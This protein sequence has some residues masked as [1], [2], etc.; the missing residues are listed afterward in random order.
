MPGVFDRLAG[1][2]DVVAELTAAASAARARV[3][4]QGWDESDARMVH[5]WLFTG[6]PG[7]GRSVAATCFAAA[8][9][10]EHPE[11][12]GCGECRSCHTVLA[13]THADVHLLA[14]QGVNILL[15]DVKETIHRAASRPSTGRWQIVVVEEADRLTEQSGNALLKVVEE[16]PS[17]TVFLLCS[18][19]TDPMDIMVTLRSRSR[20]VALR[21]PD[22]AAVESALL[23]GGGIDPER[24]RWAAAVSSGHIGRAR[25]L[26]TDEA[27][28][29]RR[30]VVLE[31][32]M[33]MHNPGRAFPLA[34][35]LVSA[36]E[37]EALARN[38]QNDEREVE[39]LRTAMGVGGTGKGAVAAGRGAAGAVKELEKA[40]KSRRTRSTRDS[41][42]LALV[43]LAGFYRDALMAGLGV[44]DVA[45]VHP[46]KAE[47]SA[48]LGGHYP[49]ASVLGAIEAI[50][51]CRAAIEVNV[52]PKFAV[53]AMVGAIREALG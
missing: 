13:G 9:Q 32:P 30:D 29:E 21:Q 28:R 42:D 36:A 18:P 25:W 31:L 49:P 6:P 50:Q 48:R 44:A 20:N 35:R 51:E 4:G 15:K 12:V 2:A 19:T 53:S 33:V 43:D 10:C 38:T 23:A 52:K 3:P 1:Q 22:A 7:S 8:L 11:I 26:A 14:P 5:A 17:R 39:E 27:T 41:L 16:P 47:E 45:P 37:Q 34:D 24:A 46:D 40:Q